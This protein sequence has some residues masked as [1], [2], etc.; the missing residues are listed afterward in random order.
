M[1]DDR[2]TDIEIGGHRWTHEDLE[3]DFTLTFSELTPA[4]ASELTDAHVLLWLA[5]KVSEINHRQP[6]PAKALRA[7]PGVAPFLEFPD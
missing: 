2:I 3:G 4:V 1:R 5:Q 7:D 6:F